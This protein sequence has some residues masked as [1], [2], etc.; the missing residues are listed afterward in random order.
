MIKFNDAIDKAYRAFRKS[1]I[2][3]LDVLGD[4]PINDAIEIAAELLVKETQQPDD[5]IERL[6]AIVDKLPH[7]VD[8]VPVV[9]GEI[10][11]I[12][13]V[14]EFDNGATLKL[15]AS[16][17]R[18]LLVLVNYPNV[19]FKGQL[20]STREAADAAGKDE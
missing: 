16:E 12:N 19:L 20:F 4:I 18:F 10:F 8:D 5:E 2:I 9:P 13:G 15:S 7:T 6:Q 1:G 14:V 11:Y 17:Q 3:Q